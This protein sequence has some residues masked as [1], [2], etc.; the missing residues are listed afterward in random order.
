M[1]EGTK[2]QKLMTDFTAFYRTYS[3]KLTIA[4]IIF[5]QQSDLASNRIP[6]NIHED[7]D[8]KR[9]R[10]TLSANIESTTIRADSNLTALS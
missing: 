2:L 8:A 6:Y 10:V 1:Y 5:Y 4:L 7:H 3:K 9:E